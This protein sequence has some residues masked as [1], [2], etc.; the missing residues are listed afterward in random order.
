MRKSVISAIAL[1]A[2][3]APAFAQGEV[4]LYSSRHYDTD[5]ALYS[6]FTEQ[7]GITVNRIEDS[8][9]TLIARMAS[10]GELSPA[11]LLLTVDVTRLTR[12]AEEGLLQPIESAVVE[13]KVPSYL[14]EDDHLWIGVSTRVRHIFYDNE[15]VTDVPE[16]WEDLADPKYEG[17]ICTR[18]SSNVYMLSLLA[19]IIAHNGEEAA[20]EWV[21]GLYNNLARPPQGGDTDQ[22][23]AVISGECDIV[24]SNHYYY[25]RGLASEVTGLTDG[26]ERL[27]IV[28]PNQDSYG[29]HVN[30][31]GIGLAVN[32]P[33]AENAIRFIEYLLSDEA[34]K[35]LA[36]GNNEYPVVEGVEPSE[37]VQQMGTDFKRDELP[38]SELSA[39]VGL[40]QEIYNEVGYP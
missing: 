38:L 23:R 4:N 2:M 22:L 19:S 21:E 26:I 6:N 31:S 11:D 25:A 9:D 34:Q 10:E 13:E 8:G 5:E 27:G 12:A 28:Y 15:D 39:N 18:S 3:T 1:A 40:A 16:T 36:D 32:A 17:M 24:I 30:I 35:M 37:A 29:T 7:T 20:R 14:Q 33:N